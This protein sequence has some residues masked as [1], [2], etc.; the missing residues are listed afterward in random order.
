M[1]PRI[2]I[3]SSCFRGASWQELSAAIN[4]L[5]V[6]RVSFAGT[7]PDPAIMR[8]VVETGGLRLESIVHPFLYGRQ[9][10][11]GSAVIAEEQEKLSQVIGLVASLQGGS[12]FLST[13]GRGALS[14]EQ[15]AETFS[16]A[17]AP[18]IAEAEAAGVLLMVE[19]TPQLYADV[20][21]THTLRD[22]IILAEMAGIGV[23][24]D[25]FS[26][27]TEAGLDQLIVRAMPRCYLIQVNDYVHGDRSYPCRAV[28]GDGAIPL[29]RIFELALTAG[30]RGVFDLEMSGPRIDAEG[31]LPAARRGVEFIWDTL[32]SLGV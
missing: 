29:R 19:N 27:W 14:W 12:I 15:A 23:C 5:G 10:D 28:P 9:L 17:I 26:C 6:E 3:N 20:T 22:T 30:Y 21:I 32:H 18:S 4:A 16:E 31:H 8:P 2:S 24:L 11:E 7:V 25:V 13:G 1:H